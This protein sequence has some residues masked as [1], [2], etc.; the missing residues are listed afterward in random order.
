MKTT[1]KW[2]TRPLESWAKAKDMRA[3]F[4]KSVRDSKKEKVLLA[5]SG[6]NAIWAL[7][8]P[9]IRVVED[10]PMGAMMAFQSNKLARDSRL[11]CEVRGWGR[12]ICGYQLNCWGA[13]YLDTQIDGSKFPLRDLVIPMPDPCDQHT[14][15]GQLPMDYSNIPRWQGDATIYTGPQNAI[16]D[17]AFIENRVGCILDQIQDI[18]RVTGQKF[19]DE[20]LIKTLKERWTYD[21]YHKDI[22]ALIQHIPAPIG[23]KELYSFYTLGGLTLTDPEETLALWKMLK[24]EVQWRADNN[25]AAVGN[26]RYRWIE[27]HPPPWHFLSYY[28]Y[29]EKYGAVCIGSQYTHG[30]GFEWKPDGTW[31]RTKTPIEMGLPLKTREDAI[32]AMHGLAPRGNNFK[33]DEIIHPYAVNDMARAFKVDGAVLALWRGGVGCTYLRKEQGRRLSEMGVR[34]MHYEG[35]QPGDR[36]DLDE[37]RLLDQLDIWMESQGLHK[38]DN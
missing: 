15:R 20:K 12:E 33:V 3:R 2:E 11:A 35:S 37:Y 19:D 4:E 18:E 16:R 23:Q 13:Q 14:K 24:D 1:Q 29:M 17:R 6:G 30:S 9:A 28:R 22:C 25:I 8:F 34:V 21:A 36:T 10:N 7:A 26:E 5:Q 38:L 27:A 31:G 32:R